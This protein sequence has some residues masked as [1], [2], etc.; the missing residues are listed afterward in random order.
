MSRLTRRCANTA[1][2]LVT[3][4]GATHDAPGARRI[5]TVGLTPKAAVPAGPVRLAAKLE[6]APNGEAVAGGGVVDAK[7]VDAGDGEAGGAGA[8]DRVGMGAE[9]G[10]HCHENSNAVPGGGA[11]KML[12]RTVTSTQY[13]V[14]ELVT[15]GATVTYCSLL[16]HV[17]LVP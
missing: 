5:A 15:V 7:G 10:D 2:P 8:A 14:V 11:S 4:C 9:A 1:T 16:E 6:H 17:P 13:S 12:L 3:R